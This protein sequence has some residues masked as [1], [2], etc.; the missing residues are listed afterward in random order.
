MAHAV[1]PY[2][3]KHGVMVVAAAGNEGNSA[4][5][6]PA[7]YPGVLSVAATD[8]RDNLYEWSTRG[9]WV[10]VAAPAAPGRR[11]KGPTGARCGTSASAPTVAGAA[12]L[13][14]SERPRA[15][16]SGLI[17]AIRCWL[18]VTPASAPTTKP[19]PAEGL[20]FS[21]HSSNNGWGM[22]RVASWPSPCRRAPVQQRTRRW[23]R[24]S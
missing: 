23:P 19:M 24:R 8:Q 11:G 22:P 14:L 13:L 7:A 2:A 1:Y 5:F 10:R 20:F 18:A 12:G 9:D 4:R 21:G 17:F 16:R 15:T 3:H 6:Y